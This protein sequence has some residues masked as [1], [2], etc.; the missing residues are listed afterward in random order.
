MN[1]DTNTKLLFE[2]LQAF[3]EDQQTHIR[4]KVRN[5][6]ISNNELQGLVHAKYVLGNKSAI[7]HGYSFGKRLLVGEDL[8]PT[9]SRTTKDSLTKIFKY[10]FCDLGAYDWSK[11]RAV[12]KSYGIDYAYL[13]DFK[14]LDTN[15]VLDNIKNTRIGEIT[16]PGSKISDALRQFAEQVDKIYANNQAA[17]QELKEANDTIAYLSKKDRQREQELAALKTIIARMRQ[18]IIGSANE[19]QQREALEFIKKVEQKV[20]L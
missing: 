13:L 15:S 2:A 8:K 14:P 16:T 5:E 20:G 4:N 6:T 7:N 18:F 11:T 10:I 9:Y 19:D 3:H 17:K 12:I 1:K